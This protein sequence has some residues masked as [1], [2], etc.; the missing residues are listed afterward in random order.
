M[1]AVVFDTPGKVALAD[2]PEPRLEQPTDALVAI[3][4]AAICGTDLHAL[5]GVAGIPPGTV[6]GH[7]FTGEII[8]VGAAVQ[9]RKVGELVNASDFTACG[10]CWW[11]RNGDHWECEDRSF[12]GFGSVFG[13]P[14]RG[15]Q[16]EMIRVPHAD[17]VLC[18]V[19]AHCSS[20]AAVFVGDTL[21]CGFAAAE[22]GGLRP[23]ETVA[24]VGGG[25]VGQMASLACQTVGAA[26]VVVSDRLPTRLQA[27]A[28]NGAIPASPEDVGAIVAE[29]TDGRGADLA[30][31]AVGGQAPLLAACESV[32]RRGRI[33]SVGAHFDATFPLSVAKAF[34]EELT[35]SFAIGDSIRLRDR[36][37]PLL[38]AGIL[39]PTAVVT[40]T[41]AL[42]GV[43]EAYQRMASHEELKVLIHP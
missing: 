4:V 27:A 16:T 8:A 18:P 5:H 33:V 13:A 7:E 38:S 10:R 30:I 11:C 40:D 39:D 32:R 20:E 35:L 12:F 34:A 17:T 3:R 15:A 23:G 42:E 31:D 43:P 29:L 14:L 25:A 41:V 1:R 24:I 22:R 9:Q 36:I 2:V 19:P 6:L 37:F 26:A 28:A 21:A